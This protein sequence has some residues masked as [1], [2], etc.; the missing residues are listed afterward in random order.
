LLGLTAMVIAL[1]FDSAYAVLTGRAGALLSQRRVRL[2]S[3]ASGLC[4]ISG[5]AW[6]ALARSR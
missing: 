3:R 6:L 2:L 1:I 4:L 5:G